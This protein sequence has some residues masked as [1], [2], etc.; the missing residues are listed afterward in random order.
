M[1]DLGKAKS[2][3]G[4]RINQHEGGIDFDQITNV[5][6]IL[7]PFGMTECKPIGTPSDTQLTISEGVGV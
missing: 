7:N 5:N 4:M 6:D 1:K 2:V 3:L